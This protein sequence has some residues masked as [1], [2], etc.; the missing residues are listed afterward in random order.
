MVERRVQ[1]FD[2]N[3]LV[4]EHPDEGLAAGERG[5][6]PLDHH[7]LAHSGQRVE[8]RTVELGHPADGESLEQL[9][10]AELDRDGRGHAWKE[11]ASTR[12][13]TRGA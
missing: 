11:K 8:A 9:V 10:L 1:I 3:G 7:R 2:R 12:A 4:D 6:D 13:R 5:E